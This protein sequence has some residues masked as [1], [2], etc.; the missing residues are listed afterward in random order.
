[1]TN[2]ELIFDFVGI[3]IHSKL[4]YQEFGAIDYSQCSGFYHNSWTW[5]MSVI[6]KID[7]LHSQKFKYVSSEIAKG[8]WPEDNEY[9]DVISLPLSTPIDDVHKAV[10]KFIKF[11]NEQK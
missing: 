11:Y 2:N 6:N 8:N 3:E 7:E 5:I 4:C 9:M 1:M 10:I